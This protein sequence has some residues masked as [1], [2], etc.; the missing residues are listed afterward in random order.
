MSNDPRNQRVVVS[1]SR[2]T[3]IS[4]PSPSLPAAVARAVSGIRV[5]AAAD[6]V[7]IVI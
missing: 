7:T 3:P 5:P 6:K 2:D 4:R 1:K